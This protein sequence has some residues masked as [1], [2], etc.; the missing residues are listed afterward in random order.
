MGGGQPRRVA[1]G[2]RS[3]VA[4]AARVVIGAVCSLVVTTGAAAV[5]T[6]TVGAAPAQTSNEVE[7]VIVA[8]VDGV[9]GDAAVV[10]VRVELTSGRA[11]TVDLSVNWELANEEGFWGSESRSFRVELPAAAPVTV[12][13]SAQRFPDSPLNLNASV[14]S[15][16]GRRLAE[17]VEVVAPSDG[18]TLVG[19]GDSLARGGAPERTSSVAGI[20]Q[21]ELVPLEEQGLARPGLLASLS[22]VVLGA[23]DTDGLSPEQRSQLRDW[24]WTGGTLVLDVA[25]SD[26]LP[27]VDLP[28]AG[29]RTAVGAGWVRF[30]D[31]A[32]AAGRWDRVVE[33]AVQRTSNSAQF[34][35]GFAVD[36]NWEFLNLIQISFLPVW[37]VFGAVFGTALVA[38]P[39]LWF[40]LRNR[41]R[42]RLMWIGAPL[43]SLLVA[44]VVLV[45][46]QGV[47]ARSTALA[48]GEAWV[49]PW[50]AR[51]D[52]VSGVKETTSIDLAGGTEVLGSSPAARVQDTG[53]GSV[54]SLSLQR[55]SFGVI[56]IGP[57]GLT[58]EAPVE[59]TA[60]AGE[61]TT[62]NVSITNR[63]SGTL[64]SVV[65]SGAGRAR[66]FEDVP[67]GAT[68]TLP[69]EMSEEVPP[70]GEPFPP[71]EQV[72]QFGLDFG[73]EVV[74]PNAPNPSV[75]VSRGL[76][77]ISGTLDMDVE[78]LGVAAE[79][80]IT[81]HAA[82]PVQ[83]AEPAPAAL[84]ID[85]VG[86]QPVAPVDP[87][88]E[89]AEDAPG[90][91]TTS[92]VRV[93]SAAGRPGSECAVHTL[94][95][96]VDRWDG[97][98]WI[99]LE[100]VGQPRKNPRFLE[101][102]EVQDWR[103]PPLS[104]GEPLFLRLQTGIPVTPVLLFDC[105]G[106]PR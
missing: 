46:G 35:G 72:D 65:V 75:P 67:A 2:D 9:A 74:N 42:R 103:F 7:I 53:D 61:G 45:L 21:A 11:R 27:V 50:G 33:P 88:G 26:V 32:A 86:P 77:M 14:A 78:A 98:S 102:N 3:A 41:D 12:D 43:L 69:F 95:R 70:F 29:A 64:Q 51:G 82:A 68:V 20:Q 80:T 8:G 85:A 23:A 4:R 100:Q 52:V 63:S 93:S 16:D 24:V 90:A 54:A 79:G 22:S 13:L 10:P 40:V 48:I 101:P 73:G 91:P 81:V 60:V 57:V 37:L 38:G 87:L 89:P 15:T 36:G 6:A 56:G 71:P 106:A 17:L 99:P 49:T 84:R 92:Y 30:S 28:S 96:Q 1:G 55:N 83:A 5:G 58:E 47:F 66:P 39:L 104:P 25:P 34:G 62:A 19:I 18:V 94:A 76:V 97:T 31:G 105:A 59:V 44:A